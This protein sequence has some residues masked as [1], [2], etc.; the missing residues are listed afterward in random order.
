MRQI[1]GLF[2]RLGLRTKFIVPI[3]ATIILSITAV[4]FYLIDRQEDGYRRELE[5]SGETLVSILALQAESGVLFENRFELAALVE[6][7][8]VFTDVQYAAIYT[9]DGVPL[10]EFGNWDT[11]GYEEIRRLHEDP[12]HGEHTELT[13][14]H[15]RTSGDDEFLELNCPV[16]TVRQSIGREVLGMTAGPGGSTSEQETEQIGSTKLVLS[17]KNVNADITTAR[18]A[19][20]LITGFVVILTIIILASF[21]RA[22]TSPVKRLVEVTNR[23]AR[24]DLSQRVDISE[25]DEIGQLG[26]TFNKM[27]ESLEQSHREIE[28]YSRTLEEKI[29]DRTQELEAAQAQLIQSEKM[30]AIGQLAAGVAHELNNPLG[31]ILGYAQFTLEKIRQL[32]P[33]EIDQKSIDKFGRY[34]ADIETQARRCKAIV[35]NLLRFSRASHA[36]EFELVDINQAIEETITFVEHQFTMNQ[37]TLTISLDDDLPQ[38][39]G[40]TGQLQQVFTNLLINAMHASPPDS[41]VRIISRYAPAVGEFDGAIELLFIDPGC[42]ISQEHLSKIFEPFFTTKE[43]GKGTGLGLSVSYGIIREH[44]GE[45][46]VDS[47]PG[48]GTTFTIYL[49][50][51]KDRQMS[52]TDT[53]HK[54]TNESEANTDSYA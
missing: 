48:K 52:D 8:E 21:V 50:V 51:Q 33:N 27:I 17:L 26:N 39:Y 2:P 29:V 35:Q 5:T 40:N 34:L 47:E 22:I 19:A 31:G 54:H 10:A 49:P 53:E 11:T 32:Q 13:G 41:E 42:G 18:F 24:G 44:S 45:I 38:I 36:A 25:R 23:V 14:A 4:S 1:L 43:V 15:V 9:I 28:E 37:L 46:K 30:G 3:S 6:E 7:L 12:L 20:I 16:V